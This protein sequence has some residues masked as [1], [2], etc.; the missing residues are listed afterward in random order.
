MT[1]QGTGQEMGPAPDP[2]GIEAPASISVDASSVD[3][4]RVR[5]PTTLAESLITE[6]GWTRGNFGH[7]GPNPPYLRI[8]GKLW[9]TLTEFEPCFSSFHRDRLL[10]RSK[11]S[12]T[13][14]LSHYDQ[15][16]V[17]PLAFE[18]RF[19]PRQGTDA[20]FP[21]GAWLSIREVRFTGIELLGK[22]HGPVRLPLEPLAVASAI[23]LR[24]TG[25]TG[26]APA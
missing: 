7:D 15:I 12:M 1:V 25:R 9:L 13:D 21:F 3:A 8:G 20:T 18:D 24:H 11:V 2:R 17:D 14:H 6:A 19:G 10:F 23:W 16:M 4:A 5:A 26:P 22:R